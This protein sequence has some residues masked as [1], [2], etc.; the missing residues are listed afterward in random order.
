MDV[1]RILEADHRIAERLIA[2]IH[3]T[4]GDSRMTLIEQ[5]RD[6]L[7]GHMELEETS[8]YPCV[9]EVLDEEALKEANTEHELARKAL[10]D[11]MRLAPDEPGFGAAFEA[12]AASI[13]HHIEG[14]ENDVFPALRNHTGAMEAMETPFVQRR[15][16]LG[17]EMSGADLAGAFTKEELVREARSA[18]VAG[19]SRLNKDEL[20]EALAA[21]N[22][23]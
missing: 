8:V 16:A 18:G 14:E 21:K 22:T 19:A 20:A 7:H 6:A 1:T 23:P 13:K 15:A 4:N 9:K 11:V 5:L 3:S 10:A 12:L 17:M 2:D